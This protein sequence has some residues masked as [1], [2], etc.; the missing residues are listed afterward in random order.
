MWTTEYPVSNEGTH[1][2]GSAAEA[3]AWHA[4]KRRP[5]RSDQRI[6][7]RYRRQQCCKTLRRQGNLSPEGP[8]RSTKPAH[9]RTRLRTAQSKRADAQSLDDESTA[10]MTTN[11]TTSTEETTT[12][13]ANKVAAIC[14]GARGLVAPRTRVFG[15]GSFTL[16]ERERCRTRRRT[17]IRTPIETRRRQAELLTEGTRGVSSG[18]GNVA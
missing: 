11:K 1:G 3:K 4:E 9:K 12:L 7:G 18:G 6:N 17:D 8:E 16:V 2:G 10:W 15:R 14:G 13:L 5:P